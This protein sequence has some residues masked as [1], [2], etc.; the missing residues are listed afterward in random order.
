M[1]QNL[2]VNL[3]V[4]LQ[5]LNFSFDE[6]II[7]FEQVFKVK[8]MP[9][10]LE[11]ILEYID[12]HL[13]NNIATAV[14]PKMK[15]ECCSNDIWHSHGWTTKTVKTSMGKLKLRLKRMK[16]QCQTTHI[17]FHLFFGL[18]KK[19]NFSNELQKKC[20]EL[21][22]NQSYR[23]STNQLKSIGNLDIKKNELYRIVNS[24]DLD[25]QNTKN[26]KNINSLMAD[27]TGY[28]PHFE[29][30]KSELKIV[31][32]LDN[33]NRPIPI[34][35]WI[36]KSWKSI[37]TELKKHNS[38][39]NKKLAFKPIANVLI[40]DGEIAL[41]KG[42]EHLAH[43]QQRCQWHFVRDFKNAYVYLEKGDK[44]TCR[45]IQNQIYEH[46]NNCMNSLKKDEKSVIDS[47]VKAEIH[48]EELEK[49][50]K[51]EKFNKAS[52]YV[53]NARQEIFTHLKII[54]T[55]GED[56]Y[57][58][59]SLIERVMRELARRFKRI[60]HN[61]S[62][63]GAERLARMLLRFTLDK[64]GWD[65]VWSQKIIITGNFKMETVGIFPT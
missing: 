58:T 48:L 12:G 26:L 37:G 54:L 51:L 34:G 35:A 47:I 11:V 38:P 18:S 62:E 32:G 27:G 17:P 36:F 8:G 7:E 21:V 19:K 40:T 64:K 24:C 55:T 10:I 49:K 31:V 57:R 25:F 2:S 5:E 50:L 28:K 13:V 52:I 4:R 15:R 44:S 42:L 30:Q 3:L 1:K 43:H 41:I 14:I 56:V 59:T 33:E 61:W 46:I 53:R 39:A 63:A 6:V 16:C 45:Q 20:C 65:K 22:C 60:A 29:D 9:G 23:R